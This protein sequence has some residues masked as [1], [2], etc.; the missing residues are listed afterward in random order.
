MR[1]RR[2]VSEVLGAIVV[3]ILVL[4]MSVSYI[5]LEMERAG[6]ETYSIIDLIRKAERRQ[7]QLLSLIFYRRQGSDLKLYIYNYGDEYSTPKRILTDR[8]VPLSKVRMRN[9]DTG[10]EVSSIPPKT[11]VELTLPAPSADSFTLVII[12]EEG[13][14]FSWKISV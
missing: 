8:E 7:R 10:E 14:V 13:G 6:R 4:G 5:L 2:G 1:G 9:M 11:L 12:T 3:A